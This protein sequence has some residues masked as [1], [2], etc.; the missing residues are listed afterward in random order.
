MLQEK[1]MGQISTGGFAGIWVWWDW[2]FGFWLTAWF[3]RWNAYWR[4]A[5][6]AVGVRTIWAANFSWRILNRWVCYK[7][8]IKK[9]D[10]QNVKDFMFHDQIR[11]SKTPSQR[12]S[13][14][15]VRAA[16][17]LSASLGPGRGSWKAPRETETKWTFY[18]VLF[19][20]S[21]MPKSL[22]L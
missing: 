2:R 1:N 7:W 4:W 16:P 6:A 14:S 12:A 19:C 13:V 15:R 8:S 3:W 9:P 22:Y 10:Y 20:Q 11:S 21:C 17:L 5:F 18:L